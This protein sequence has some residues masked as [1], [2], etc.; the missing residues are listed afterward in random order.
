MYPSQQIKEARPRYPILGLLQKRWS[1]RAFSDKPVE[2]EKL[3]IVF[4]AARWSPSALNEQPW[5]FIVGLKG[6]PT[7][8]AIHGLLADTNRL[9]AG[10]APILV[11]ACGSSRFNKDGMPNE[12]FAYDVGQCVA[13]L[14]IQATELDLYVHQMRGFDH[15]LAAKVFVLPN[16]V[17]ALTV[18]AIGYLGDPATLHPRMQKSELA[19]RKRK[20]ADDFVFSVRFGHRIRL[21]QGEKPVKKDE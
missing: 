4:E 15:D 9:W 10:K 19:P 13:H 14:S 5:S 20:D 17:V 2:E 1:P 21:F 8:Q 16:E 3:R 12:T 7:H 6:D 11:L 18:V